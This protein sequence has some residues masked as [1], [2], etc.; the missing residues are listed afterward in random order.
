MYNDISTI[1][2]GE[3]RVGLKEKGNFRSYEIK[4]YKISDFRNE[5]RCTCRMQ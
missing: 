3:Y 1:E 5:C 2:K 4:I